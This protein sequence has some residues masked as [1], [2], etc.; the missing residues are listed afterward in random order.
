MAANIEIGKSASPSNQPYFT[1]VRITSVSS[2]GG[3]GGV[4]YKI[5]ATVASEV[6][7]GR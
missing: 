7:S 4:D 5:T 3:N 2:N 1:D 6:T